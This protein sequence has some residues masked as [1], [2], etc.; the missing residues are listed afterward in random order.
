MTDNK[1]KRDAKKIM[2]SL[3]GKRIYIKMCR[4][5]EHFISNK[6]VDD[7]PDGL[8]CKKCNCGKEWIVFALFLVGKKRKFQGLIR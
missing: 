6:R 3:K 4:G 1:I 8:H 2:N 5:V 7:K